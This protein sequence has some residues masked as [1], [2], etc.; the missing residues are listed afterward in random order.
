MLTVNLALVSEVPGHDP[1]DVARVAAAP[2]A[3][4]HAGLRPDLGRAGDRRRV[5]APR[6]RAGRLL[7]DDRRDRHQHPRR[8]RRPRGQGRPALRADRDVRQLVADR[9]PRDARDARRPVRQPRDRRASRPSAARAASSSWSRS[10]I[11]READ[12]FAYTVNDILVSDFYH[13]RASSTPSA[14]TASATASPGAIT[15]PRAD[16]ARR[17]HQLAR[18]GLGPL[19]AADLV[20]P[21]QAVPRP[22]RLRRGGAAEPAL[23]GRRPDRPSRAS[24]RA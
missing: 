16:P 21:A 8:R 12:E 23:L 10:A 14:P 11:R 5:P 20:R 18:P 13:A 1:S 3:P 15:E 4:G 19:V 17:L 24:T 9:Q 6:G 2:A 22:R 7:A